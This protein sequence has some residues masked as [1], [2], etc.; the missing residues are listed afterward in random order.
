MRARNLVLCSSL[1]LVSWPAPAT[2]K[3][4]KPDSF[5]IERIDCSGEGCPPA[6]VS[7]SA[8]ADAG[9][10]I[11]LYSR[12]Y[13]QAAPNVDA[14]FAKR[15]C[16]LHL[17][18]AV[19]K[20]WSYA[21]TAVDFRGFAALDASVD[22]SEESSY[23]M[24]GESP[25]TTAAFRRHGA[26]EDEFAVEDIGANA[27][28]Y[29]SRCGGGKNLM[30]TTTIAVDAGANRAGSGLLELDDVDGQLFHVAWRPCS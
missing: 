14:A 30:I 28:P 11:V 10:F 25:E 26:F 24:S 29:W 13:A 1:A 19:P 9:A 18:L 7:A 6:S 15:K 17:Q 3:K 5:A 2:A 27:P 22:A 20:G 21:L 4:A 12:M 8:T 23:H 16:Q